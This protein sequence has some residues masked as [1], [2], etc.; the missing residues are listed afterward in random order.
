MLFRFAQE[1]TPSFA[2][3]LLKMTSMDA[4]APVASASRINIGIPQTLYVM[5][6]S[7][8]EGQHSGH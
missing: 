2:A 3:P 7:A 5:H 1:T 8:W 4:K 6:L